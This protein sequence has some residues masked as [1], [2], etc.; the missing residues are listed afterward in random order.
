MVKEIEVSDFRI[1]RALATA[2]STSGIP[3]WP[4]TRRSTDFGARD[5]AHTDTQK[6][7]GSPNRKNRAV[8]NEGQKALW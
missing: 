4:A 5:V 2:A 1:D 8:D 7:P 6:R 3:I